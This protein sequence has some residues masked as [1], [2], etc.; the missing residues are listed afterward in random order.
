M[1]SR[2]PSSVAESQNLTYLELGQV[3]DA[4]M[5]AMQLREDEVF[6]PRLEGLRLTGYCVQS[7]SQMEWIFAHGK[8]LRFLE[9][10]GA[11]IIYHA[12]L[13]TKNDDFHKI[14]QLWDHP[15]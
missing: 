5:P 13:H 9:L 2:F 6:F 4:F 10:V 1:Y 14:V 15:R 12:V 11:T 3:G 7:H 8:T